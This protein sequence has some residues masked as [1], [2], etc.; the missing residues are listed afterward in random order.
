[1]MSSS[2]SL[3]TDTHT[4][5]IDQLIRAGTIGLQWLL[6]GMAFFVFWEYRHGQR[7][8]R[9]GYV[10]LYVTGISS[11]YVMYL[12]ATSSTSLALFHHPVTWR[13][14]AILI[15]TIIGIPAMIRLLRDLK[16]RE[17]EAEAMIDRGYTKR[18]NDPQPGA[19]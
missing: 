17:A 6:I 7:L 11:S 16:R 10:P 14:I 8:G 4:A 2:A 15:G 12:I 19:H 13:N 18:R 1:M 9:G 5:A 3:S